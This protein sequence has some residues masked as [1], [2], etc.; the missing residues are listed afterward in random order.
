MDDGMF[1]EDILTIAHHLE[2]K[3]RLAE[4][5]LTIAGGNVDLVFMANGDSRDVENLI[6]HVIDERINYIHRDIIN[7]FRVIEEKMNRRFEALE[8][9]FE[10]KKVI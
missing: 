4:D 8:C 10:L 9:R 7:H 5:L 3:E 6:A 1:A 2:M